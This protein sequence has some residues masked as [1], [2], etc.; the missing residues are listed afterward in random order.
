VILART[1][2]ERF[3][4]LLSEFAKFAGLLIQDATVAFNSYLLGLENDK[5][6]GF[7]ALNSGIMLATLF[8]FWPYR[9]FVW[10]APLWVDARRF[11]IADHVHVRRLPATADHTDLLRACEEVRQ[12]QL[13]QSRPLWQLW[14]LPGLP[15]GRVGM[16][17]RAHHAI[18]DGPAAV[19][20]LGA[21]LDH[22]PAALSPTAPPWRPRPAPAA[23]D[24]LAGNLRWYASALAGTGSY[25]AHPA[26]MAARPPGS[27]AVPRGEPGRPG[28]AGHGAGVLA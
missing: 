18:A 17:F 2:Y 4:Q 22:A 13:D 1:Q 11:D 19:T 27:A 9:Q 5:L 20:L 14:L 16:F 7:I 12:H 10:V 26:A 24:L 23:R 3:R 25:L 28:A 15:G 21:L 8:R 6:A